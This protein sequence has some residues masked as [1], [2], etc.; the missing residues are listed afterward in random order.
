MGSACDGCGSITS[1]CYRLAGDTPHTEGLKGKILCRE[2]CLT[3]DPRTWR[4]RIETHRAA[5]K[6]ALEALELNDL[7]FVL[8]VA[9]TFRFTQPHGRT[10]EKT[11]ACAT[12][13]VFRHGSEN[14][15]A[16]GAKYVFGKHGHGHDLVSNEDAPRIHAELVALRDSGS[17]PRGREEKPTARA[18]NAQD[19]IVQYKNPMPAP[20]PDPYAKCREAD[21]VP[22]EH[23]AEAF[24]HLEMC[25][26][27]MLAAVTGDETELDEPCRLPPGSLRGT[28]VH[29]RP[30]L[31]EIE[32]LL[33]R[34]R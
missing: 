19:V 6:P 34:L 28:P 16:F 7:D 14:A 15:N 22:L 3:G 21:R 9:T 11:Y 20:K 1:D 31:A 8:G 23:V 5:A 24:K 25:H 26:A 10:I 30:L 2:K 18:S 12:R 13:L 32:K 27:R 17:D 33:E 4:G 29:M